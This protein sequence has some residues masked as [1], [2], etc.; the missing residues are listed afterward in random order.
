[1]ISNAN[2]LQTFLAQTSPYNWYKQ[3]TIRKCRWKK[4]MKLA[5][6]IKG[7]TRILKSPRIL[8]IKFK[9]QVLKTGKHEEQ[10][11]SHLEATALTPSPYGQAMQLV[12][13]RTQMETPTVWFYFKL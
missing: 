11:S 2:K 7:L 12:T 13:D 4:S 5:I 1:M 9:S 6:K 8:R 10:C 3:E